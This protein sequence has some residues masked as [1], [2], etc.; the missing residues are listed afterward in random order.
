VTL[1]SETQMKMKLTPP[2]LVPSTSV[3][4][5]NVHR[6]SRNDS[7]TSSNVT[8]ATHDLPAC[9]PPRGLVNHNLL[10]PILIPSAMT[11]PIIRLRE[12]VINANMSQPVK[13]EDLLEVAWR[14]LPRLTR[15][16]HELAM[17]NNHMSRRGLGTVPGGEER[18]RVLHRG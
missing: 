11:S 8:S 4:I 16:A 13:S 10:G 6:N 18:R 15:Q 12:H 14:V 1:A 7:N 3:D 9:P 5:D 2:V 17:K